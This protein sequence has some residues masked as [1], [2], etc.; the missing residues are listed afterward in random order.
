MK[1]EDVHFFKGVAIA[2]SHKLPKTSL[3]TL[4]QDAVDLALFC[5]RK[6]SGQKG[7]VSPLGEKDM[8]ALKW[9]KY[10]SMQPEGILHH[11]EI[12]DIGEIEGFRPV[13]LGNARV[14][15]SVGKEIFGESSIAPLL[16]GAQTYLSVV[17]PFSKLSP[18]DD[19][20]GI[21]D[22]FPGVW[23]LYKRNGMPDYAVPQ[24][25]TN[26]YVAFRLAHTDLTVASLFNSFGR[27]GAGGPQFGWLEV[28]TDP[29][30]ADVF[31]DQ[32]PIGPSPNRSV[33]TAG[34]HQ[35]KAQKQKLAALQRANVQA[36]QMVKVALK[37]A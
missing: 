5:N 8:L 36:A 14:A 17:V 3:R 22:A 25:V 23:N 24:L 9:I 15:S 18:R 35:L 20:E 30:P 16:S 21:N 34:T 27:L 28:T 4:D 37:L 11:A 26:E 32:K 1:Q 19:I 2:A 6:E 7:G 31:L 12:L 13:V 10:R 33:T 29:S